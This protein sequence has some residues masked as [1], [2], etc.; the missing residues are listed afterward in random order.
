MTQKQLLIFS[1][2]GLLASVSSFLFWLSFG[3]LL[4]DPYPL[5]IGGGPKIWENG[6]IFLATIAVFLAL[7]LLVSLLLADSIFKI[8]ILL[9]ASL[10]PVFLQISSGNPLW[11]IILTALLLFIGLIYCSHLVWLEAKNHLKLRLAHLLGPALSFFLLVLS[12]ILS[13]HY[14]FAAAGKTSD[15][16]LEI[17]DWIMEKA[18]QVAST[19]L[20]NQLQQGQESPLNT[21]PL[22]ANFS[23]FLLG[24]KPIPHEL[25]PL[26]ESRAIPPNVAVELERQ[27]VD[28]NII[29]P[30]IQKV[31]LDENGFLKNPQDFQQLLAQALTP[32]DLLPAFKNQVQTQLNE[33][34]KTYRRFLPVIFT[35]LFFILLRSLNGLVEWL[36]VLVLSAA[37]WFLKATKLV[38]LE[39]ETVQAERLVVK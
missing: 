1:I 25:R 30:I 23:E 6:L 27:G 16:K 39:Q 9:F 21:L 31:E 34:I 17:P 12:V 2:L 37:L 28:P 36:A 13:L 5:L 18:L 4:L 35:A 29:L 38:S 11:L 20:I 32:T 22:P 15:F 8:V 14:Y 7:I 26:L 24:R 33:I 19:S 10:P 3:R